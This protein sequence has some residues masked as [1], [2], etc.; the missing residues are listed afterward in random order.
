MS[1]I[2]MSTLTTVCKNFISCQFLIELT[3][4]LMR[5]HAYYFTHLLPLLVRVD[6]FNHLMHWQWTA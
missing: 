4:N 3:K 5:W 1:D 2:I 6:L